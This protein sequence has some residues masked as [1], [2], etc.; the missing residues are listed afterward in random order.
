MFFLNT[1]AAQLLKKLRLLNQSTYKDG[2]K[3]VLAFLSKGQRANYVPQNGEFTRILKEM[4][5]EMGRDSVEEETLVKKYEERTGA[6]Q[7]GQG[8]CGT[9]YC[10]EQYLATELTLGAIMQENDE[11]D[12]LGTGVS[13]K[14]VSVGGAHS[15]K[16]AARSNKVIGKKLNMIF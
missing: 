3:E 6:M 9:G 5:D 13:Q 11:K 1:N 7:G 15:Q 14:P 10:T 2:R 16:A 4:D 8:Y 12:T